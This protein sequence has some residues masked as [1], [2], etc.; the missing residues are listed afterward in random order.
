MTVRIFKKQD[1]LDRGLPDYCEDG[2]VISDRIV[3]NGRWSIHHELIFRLDGVWSSNRSRAANG[4]RISY[5]VRSGEI[6][7]AK[8]PGDLRSF[9]RSGSVSTGYTGPWKE[10]GVLVE[11]ARGPCFH[12]LNPDT[13]ARRLASGALFVEGKFKV[14][15]TVRGGDARRGYASFAPS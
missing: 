10:I 3:G 4:L 14:V 11:D 12:V 13:T 9:T 15:S 8:Y 1:L 5:G 6:L 2:E 7:R